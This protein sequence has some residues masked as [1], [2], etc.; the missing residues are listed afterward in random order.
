MLEKTVFLTL[1][2]ILTLANAASA[3]PGCPHGLCHE[4]HHPSAAIQ[5]LHQNLSRSHCPLFLPSVSMQTGMGRKT[6]SASQSKALWIL[7]PAD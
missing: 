2:T 4:P 6:T 7:A 5:P 3:R 1:F